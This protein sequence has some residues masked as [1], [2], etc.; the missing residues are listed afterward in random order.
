MP[1]IPAAHASRPPAKR[2]TV[3]RRSSCMPVIKPEEWERCAALLSLTQCAWS[4]MCVLAM[5][6]GAHRYFSV[7]AVGSK[8]GFVYLWRCWAKS[9]MESADVRQRFQM[10]G[11]VK[12]QM[13]VWASHLH[14]VLLPKQPQGNLEASPDEDCTSHCLVLAIGYSDGSCSLFQERTS[15]MGA[16]DASELGWLKMQRMA[17]LWEPDEFPTTSLY[18]NLS[19]CLPS[20]ESILVVMA[21][22]SGGRLAV[23]TSPVTGSEPGLQMV[24]APQVYRKDYAHGAKAVT[25]VHVARPL[26]SRRADGVAEI[27]LFSCGMDGRLKMWT[28]AS[29]G[30]DIKQEGTW[31][32]G[33]SNC[34]LYGMGLSPN[35]LFMAVHSSSALL[36]PPSAL[37]QQSFHTLTKG[38]VHLLRLF[39]PGTSIPCEAAVEIA[40]ARLRQ[41]PGL[42]SQQAELA[43][44]LRCASTLQSED[45]RGLASLPAGRSTS[46]TLDSD[47]QTHSV[48][49]CQIACSSLAAREAALTADGTAQTSNVSRGNRAGAVE[50][51]G[52]PPLGDQQE[53][54][55]LAEPGYP[56]DVED[57][58]VAVDPR[59]QYIV[60]QLRDA[61]ALCWSP[62]T[63][64]ALAR[65]EGSKE[66]MEALVWKPDSGRLGNLR[67]AV[68][69]RRLV[70]PPSHLLRLEMLWRSKERGQGDIVIQP[71]LNSF[72]TWMH[73]LY[74]AEAIL[75]Q[76]YIFDQL[77]QC[78]EGRKAPEFRHL[79]MV[80][81]VLSN[82]NK[83]D[84]ALVQQ[85]QRLDRE[86]GIGE[87]QLPTS[88]IELY[89][90]LE[91]EPL[92]VCLAESARFARF[93]FQGNTLSLPRCSLNFQAC[94]FKDKVTRC[95]LC[96][97]VYSKDPPPNGSVN[98][99]MYCGMRVTAP[100]ATTILQL[101]AFKPPM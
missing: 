34:G 9:S 100:R 19:D 97:R 89:K 90:P 92:D 47:G 60:D 61:E 65:L 29:S 70:A 26:L 35:S 33:E 5:P 80:Q 88:P 17:A 27:R 79:L 93:S 74:R 75:L 40:L 39:G 18:A 57:I 82:K 23:W 21:G 4:P 85:C 69:L 64:R 8:S 99:C 95:T 73:S 83:V 59:D 30:S 46:S 43:E 68:A 66:S 49:T 16:H 81:W 53:G 12:G 22:K 20:G 58:D 11:A 41:D 78:T 48:D 28:L 54:S 94:G 2:R 6:D 45:R 84:Q 37:L 77:S 71:V 87:G 32:T 31:A 25:E 55:E 91:A 7:L 15:L 51:E 62:L 76:C 13:G 42:P 38:H 36:S 52:S 44:V 96:G 1:D 98:T 3:V 63:T 10:I 72:H 101:P 50:H 86:F 56:E 24:Q 67:L 14:W